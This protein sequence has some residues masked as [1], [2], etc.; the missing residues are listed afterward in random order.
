M[1]KLAQLLD[2]YPRLKGLASQLQWLEDA[3]AAALQADLG[4]AG[5]VVATDLRAA[6]GAIVAF[7]QTP[8][9]DRDVGA[10]S[11]L[12]QKLVGRALQNLGGALDATYAGLDETADSEDLRRIRAS[13]RALTHPERP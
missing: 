3:A 10:L 7:A 5:A 6:L 12:V 11:A 1:T 8:S 4:A 9:A 2:E 13:C